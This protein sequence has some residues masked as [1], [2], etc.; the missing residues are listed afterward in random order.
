MPCTAASAFASNVNVSEAK[1]FGS[2]SMPLPAMIPRIFSRVRCSCW[3]GS[4][5]SANQPPIRFTC[6][7]VKRTV[8]G[9]LGQ[10][11]GKQPVRFRLAE[12]RHTRSPARN[13]SP[14]KPEW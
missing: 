4:D 13:I 2:S 11:G 5:T 12:F 7:R 8:P 9:E 1:R 3:W 6:R 14:D 10:H